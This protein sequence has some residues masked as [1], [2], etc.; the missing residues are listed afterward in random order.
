M[1]ESRNTIFQGFQRGNIIFIKRKLRDER[2]RKTVHFAMLI[3]NH[4]TNVEVSGLVIIFFFF[5]GGRISIWEAL[6]P[7]T[8][9]H[10]TIVRNF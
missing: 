3:G 7:S 10:K 8:E 9:Q 6:Q 1:K 5:G 2:P 4:F